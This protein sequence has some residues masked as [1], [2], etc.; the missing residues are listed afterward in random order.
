MY[1]FI[2]FHPILFWP[3]HN[4]IVPT[5]HHSLMLQMD[6]M[7]QHH[8]RHQHL[9]NISLHL[10]KWLLLISHIILIF[11]VLEVNSKPMLPWLF[12]QESF[13]PTR[14]FLYQPEL[15][16]A[17]SDSVTRIL[18]KIDHNNYSHQTILNS[19]W[20]F[21][22]QPC[23]WYFEGARCQAHTSSCRHRCRWIQACC[24]WSWFPAPDSPWSQPS[25]RCKSRVETSDSEES[26]IWSKI[27]YYDVL[28]NITLYFFLDKKGHL[29]CSF[30]FNS[31]VI[32]LDYAFL[33][34]YS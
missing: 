2:T 3:F 12:F 7:L 13:P 30:S 16:T 15:H 5:W 20:F 31:L 21:V 29:F 9:K 28:R 25:G 14:A 4:I 17:W 32:F 1:V 27:F 33:N 8:I 34:V 24:P 22:L 6:Q 23:Y 19:D 10:L 26:E 11:P 18:N